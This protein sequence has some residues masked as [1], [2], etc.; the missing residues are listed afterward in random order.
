MI[1]RRLALERELSKEALQC[2]DVMK[3]IKHAGLMK[4]VSGLGDCYEKVVKEFLVNIPEDCDNPVSKEYQ[5]VF[6]RGKEI[7]FSPTI[8]N[9]Y[10]GR[11]EEP[12]AEMEATDNTICQAI[13]GGKVKEWPKKGK[14]QA[15]KLTPVFNILNRI[16]AANWVPTTHNCDVATGLARFIYA[17]G[18][19][20]NYDFGTY[21]FDQTVKHAKTL[22][23]KLPIAFPSLL[24]GIIL[25][26]RPD[27]LG[28]ED[29]ACRRE[30]AISFSLKQSDVTPDVGT[31]SSTSVMSRKDMIA[32]LK[33]TCKALEEKKT[34]LE[35]VIAGL[36][37]EDEQTMA[38][39]E[40]LEEEEPNDSEAEETDG[41]QDI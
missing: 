40:E 22:A 41:S 36:E 8:I 28:K 35:A 9:Q 4:T 30:T 23:V 13:T 37:L 12:C 5:K 17:V 18:N 26:Q 11:S 33:E 3:L 21:I 25:S 38:E 10:L 29:M 6:V 24:C 14:L 20:I 15:S 34:K 19:K 39:D 2:K 27:I 1:N 16:A 31:S 32:A 7:A